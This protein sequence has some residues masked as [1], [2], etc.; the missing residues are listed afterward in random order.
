MHSPEIDLPH[1]HEVV[2]NRFIAACQADERV[3]A[4]TLDGSY[5][6]SAADAY[7]DL[8]LG[9]ITTDEAYDDFVAGREA[10]M[11]RLGELVFLEDF[12]LPNI[13]FFIFAD[14]T[15][16]ELSLGRE[17]QFNH[18]HSGPYRVLLDKKNI[19][20]GTVFPR[21]QPEPAEQI[22]TLRR[23]VYWFWHDLSHFITA[24]GRGQLWWAYGQLE[25]LRRTC[26]NLA[27]LRHN[28]SAEAEGYEKVEQALPIE[29]LAPLQATFC[30]MEPEAMLQAGHA[31]LRFYQELAPPLA[32]THGIAYPDALER[33]MS[34]R[35]EKL[36]HPR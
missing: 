23:L 30:P 35:L 12:D 4:A 5:A 21:H 6:R 8:D 31:I 9:L 18:S 20:V 17:S 10:F 2:M 36:R 24:M 11:R 33:I 15:E 16:G 1:N 7:S 28:F 22:E 26:V 27:H 32:R 29:Q 34:G 3:V 14:G 13:V 25:E 19:L